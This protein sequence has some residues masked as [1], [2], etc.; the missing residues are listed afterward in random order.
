MNY[1]NKEKKMIKEINKKMKEKLINKNLK[2]N[3]KNI[4]HILDHKSY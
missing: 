1:F 4:I 3:L 2:I